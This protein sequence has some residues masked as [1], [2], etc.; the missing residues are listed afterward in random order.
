MKKEIVD[1]ET[2]RYTMGDFLNERISNRSSKIDVASGYFNATGFSI[3]RSSLWKAAESSDFRLRLLFGRE[4]IQNKTIEDPSEELPITK[5]LDSLTISER[6]A[7]LVDDLIKFLKLDKVDVK[8]N[9]KR[10]THA[11]CYI[12]DDLVAVGSSNFTGPGLHSNIELNAILYQPS[13]Q[14]LVRDWFERRWSQG[15]DAKAELIKLLE[16][17]KFGSPLDPFTAYMKFL[18]EYY[19]PRLREL[20]EAGS[21]RYE[22]ATFQEDAVR[23]AIRI[24]NRFGGVI[25][26]DS[27]GLGKT[28]IGLEILREFVAVQRKK[29]LLLAPKQ[30]IDTVWEPKL[31]EAS[32]K[33]K[34]VSIE[35]TGT[36]G[37]RPEEYL[38]YDVVLIDE[39][40]NYRN[41]STNRRLI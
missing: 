6:Y 12:L 40:Q 1:N 13:A 36:S 7:E 21:G 2:D 8:S 10:L 4:A 14:Q 9:P 11:K 19:K 3:L 32:V 15:T 25:I 34:N 30:V 18:Y 38:D 28:H 37:F 35:F 20:Q 16:E 26:A 17:S 39:S 27:T 22:L 33:T 41:P 31:L 29:A 23:T 24:I 5:E